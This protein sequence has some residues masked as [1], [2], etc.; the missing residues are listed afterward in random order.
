MVGMVVVMTAAAAAAAVV[1]VVVV[2]VVG[3]MMGSWETGL[4]RQCEQYACIP[5]CED[6]N[7][8]T[9]ARQRT[10]NLTLLC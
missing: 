10:A 7:G 3:V 5:W 6:L 4:N 2:G 8:R 9:N 1:V